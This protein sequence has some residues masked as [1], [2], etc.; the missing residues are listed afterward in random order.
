MSVLITG[1][2]GF[3]GTYL[4][5]EMAADPQGGQMIYGI[6]VEPE[7]PLISDSLEDYQVIDIT[8]RNTLRE[9]LLKIKPEVI[10]HLAAQSSVAASFKDPHATFSVNLTGTL[11]IL[12]TAV[13]DLD[14]D[15]LIILV[16]SGEIYD[17]TCPDMPFSEST[18]ISPANPYAISKASVEYLGEI[19]WKSYGL[20][21][22]RTRSFNHIGPG[23]SAGFVMP[24]FAKQIAE[25][26][27]G[28]IDPVLKVG[29]LNAQRDFTDVRDVVKA[30]ISLA[31][32]G[33]NGEAYNVCSG[34]A[35]SINDMLNILLDKSDVTVKIE[36]DPE[37]MRP[38]D[39]PLTYGDNTK[40]R[41]DTGWKPG[42][43]IKN[44][45]QDLLDHCRREI[46]S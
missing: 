31:E 11:N 27:S 26:E 13:R 17:H 46:K 7:N 29:N 20:R 4:V 15:P 22:I 5:R 28:I 35:V 39:Y 24:S 38:I 3:A 33:R 19:Y 44:T 40:I 42:I 36:Q 34:K 25:I 21:T 37:R 8:D 41:Q 12:E 6:G 16:G 9:Y 14:S 45:L 23:Q 18:R 32:K 10:Y 1:A 43:D 2:C 30:Y